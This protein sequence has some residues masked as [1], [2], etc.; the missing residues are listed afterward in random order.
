[1]YA[2]PDNFL[3]QS[4]RGN[5]RGI[6][7]HLELVGRLRSREVYQEFL[8]CLN[9][10]AHDIIGKG[11]MHTLAQEFLGHHHDLFQSF[12]RFM[13]R[14]E[15]SVLDPEDKQMMLGGRMGPRDG[16]MKATEAQRYDDKPASEC[17]VT[18]WKVD[19]LNPTPPP[20]FS[21]APHN[22]ALKT[23]F[24]AVHAL[25]SAKFSP[26]CVQLQQTISR[27]RVL[28]ALLELKQFMTECLPQLTLP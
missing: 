25:F 9:L 16:R 7:N 12:E 10:F 8:K 18:H 11:E 27:K 6:P 13:Q 20:G 22:S 3:T 24:S 1:M 21:C 15:A 28:S 17:D 4:A 14:C 5:S 19:M 23:K 2:E 26:S